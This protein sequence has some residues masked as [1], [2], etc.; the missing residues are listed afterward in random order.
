M[1][2]NQIHD[3]LIVA[4]CD[5]IVQGTGTPPE[6]IYMFANSDIVVSG[7]GTSDLHISVKDNDVIRWR[8][9]PMQVAATVAG[10]GAGFYSL[11]I[12]SYSDWGN[13][14][15]GFQGFNGQSN[16]PTYNPNGESIP[17]WHTTGEIL[18]MKPSYRPY[19]QATATLNGDPQVTNELYTFSFQ[20]FLNGSLVTTYY[21]DPSVDITP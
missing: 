16:V 17:R 12:V 13:H 4:D 8:V 1:I 19:A 6:V 9:V 20:V 10:F 15:V 21:W 11:A 5:K 18:Q 7:Q 3:V 14:L 2:R